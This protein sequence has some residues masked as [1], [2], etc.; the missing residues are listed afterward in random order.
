MDI[1]IL[2]VYIIHVTLAQDWHRDFEALKIWQIKDIPGRQSFS[3]V[4]THNDY[5]KLLYT[6]KESMSMLV[7]ARNALHN[8]SM[9]N[10]QE[11]LE[12]IEWSPTT[13]D[14]DVCSKKQKSEE[15]C[16]NF[17]QVVGKMDSGDLMVCGTNAYKPKCRSYRKSTETIGYSQLEEESGVGKCPYSPN[18]NSTFVYADGRLFGATVTDIAEQNPLILNGQMIR[19]RSHDSR[20]LNDPNFVASFDIEDKIYFFFRETAVENINCGKAVFSRVARVCKND[21]GGNIVLENTWTSFFKA[22]LNCSIPGEFP[23]YF[24]EIQST[25]DFFQGNY[26]STELSKDRQQ[27]FYAIFTTPENSIRG[28][29]VCAF[30]YEDIVQVFKGKFKGQENFGHEWLPVPDEDVPK[31]HP[32]SCSDNSQNLG[33]DT[34]NFVK[35][36][37]MM[38]S[39][40]PSFGGAPL[41]MKLSLKSR[42]TKIAIDWQVHAADNRYYDIMFVGTEDGRVLKAIN[43]G[44]GEDIESVILEDIQVFKDKR[45]VTDMKIFHDKQHG[46][47]KLIVMSRENIMSI[48]LHRCERALTCSECVALQD[49]Y[50]SFVDTTCAA[51]DRGLQSIVDGKLQACG[52]PLETTTKTVTPAPTPVV[53]MPTA[54]PQCNCSSGGTSNNNIPNAQSHS[55]LGVT[56]NT[57]TKMPPPRGMTGKSDEVFASN[58]MEESSVVVGERLESGEPS[59]LSVAETAIAIVVAIVISSILSFVAGYKVRSCTHT[60]DDNDDA[61]LTEKHDIYGSLHKNHQRT[62]SENSNKEP[63]YVNHS[64]INNSNKQLNLVVNLPKGQNLPNGNAPAMPITK[65]NLP[66]STDNKTYV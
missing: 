13:Y 60:N 59:S 37:T 27:M 57:V 7:G 49:P 22:R 6:D 42:F 9:V 8:I 15:E 55:N 25:S 1:R 23:F 51:S 36:H 29:A 19:T 62:L 12:R 64:D 48:P 16:Q 24:N 63:R 30:R 31:P 39:A 46:Q 4:S 10:L 5:F 50:C 17:I 53:A 61:F 56:D 2:I 26:R 66:V 58:Q 45:P 43:K 21:K 47:D 20:W 44:R 52:A 28:S 65:M 54:I 14:K 32:E 33:D 35:S 38:D 40:V 11:S 41:L 3:G 18:H 34:M